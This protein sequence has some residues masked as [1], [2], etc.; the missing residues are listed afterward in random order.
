[1]NITVRKCSVVHTN[2]NNVQDIYKMPNQW[3]PTDDQG[4]IIT[5]DLK[6]S[7]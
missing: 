6:W 2:H 4:I 5:K 1:M 3:L 7:K